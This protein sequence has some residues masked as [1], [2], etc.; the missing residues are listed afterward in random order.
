MQRCGPDGIEI[1]YRL[2]NSDR[3]RREHHQ[4]VGVGDHAPATEPVATHHDIEPERVATEWLM[5]AIHVH[6]RSMFEGELDS[7]VVAG[8]VHEDH[9][10]DAQAQMMVEEGG[11]PHRFVANLGE[12][13]NLAVSIGNR[14]IVDAP[15]PKRRAPSLERILDDS[16]SACRRCSAPPEDGLAR[17]TLNHGPT[18]T[19]R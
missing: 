15:Q 10:I 1:G 6:I 18:V 3:G 17:R 19:L 14:S 5:G 16:G 12:Q 8:V 11:E 2:P 9:P 7:P 13:E 4:L